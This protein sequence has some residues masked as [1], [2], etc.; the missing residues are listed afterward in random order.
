MI[1]DEPIRTAS[2]RELVIGDEAHSLNGYVVIEFIP[3]GRLGLDDQAAL[4]HRRIIKF[5][6]LLQYPFGDQDARVFSPLLRRFALGC[7]DLVEIGARR[8]AKPEA[9]ILFRVLR[10][11]MKDWHDWPLL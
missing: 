8:D 7:D 11:V 9:V 4:H 10:A 2:H 3:I 6:F 1:A 5:D